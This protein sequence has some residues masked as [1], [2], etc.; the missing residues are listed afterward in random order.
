[1]S[2]FLIFFLV[3]RAQPQIASTSQHGSGVCVV[4]VD[5]GRWAVVMVEWAVVMPSD[6]KHQSAASDEHAYGESASF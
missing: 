4:G 6:R 2:I 5:G 1:M 3:D